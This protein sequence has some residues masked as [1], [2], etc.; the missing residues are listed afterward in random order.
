MANATPVPFVGASAGEEAFADPHVASMR[1]RLENGWS[2]RVALMKALCPPEAMALDVGCAYGEYTL[3]LATIAAHVDALDISRD[4]LNAVET[5]A[6]ELNITNVTTISEDLITWSVGRDRRYDFCVCTN[7]LMLL[8]SATRRAFLQSFHRLVAEGG[9]LF[10]DFYLPR[11]LIYRV[12]IQ[13]LP[14]RLKLRSLGSYFYR[15]VRGQL[16]TK[17]VFEREASE[18]GFTIVRKG[19][20]LSGPGSAYHACRSLEGHNQDTIFGRYFQPYVLQAR[21]QKPDR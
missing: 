4:A 8:D 10:A 19:A 20:D 11:Y 17:A 12:L 15:L 6:A 5:F 16:L 21:C 13:R 3:P 18:H 1:Q 9:Y 7:T 2:A 14:L